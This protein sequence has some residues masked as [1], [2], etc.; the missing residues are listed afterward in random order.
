MATTRPVGSTTTSTSIKQQMISLI[1]EYKALYL[2]WLYAPDLLPPDAHIKTFNDLVGH[3]KMF[4]KNI[5]EEQAKVW[6]YE[7]PV[8]N[9]LKVLLKA[10]HSQKMVELY[11]IYFDKAKTDTN[12]FKAFI[13]FSDKY[14]ADENESEL[15]KIL[16]QVNLDEDEE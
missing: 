13:D 16:N 9:A 5:T 11:N 15:Q 3:Y 12:A 14:F 1:P 10:K 6:L 2:Y 8:Q 7:A 4:P